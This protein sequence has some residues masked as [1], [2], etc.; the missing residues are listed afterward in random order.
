MLPAELLQQAFF[1]HAL[2]TEPAR[3]LPPHKSLLAM[4]ARAPSAPPP[5][6]LHARVERVV[7]KAFWDEALQSLSSPSPAVQLPRLKLLYNDLHEALTPLFPPQH[8]ILLTLAAPLS[9]TSSPLHSTL[10]LLNE[11]L[12]AL[13]QRCAPARDPDIDALLAN[14]APSSETTS[15]SEAP[16]ENPLAALIVSTLRDLISLADVL[17]RDLTDTLLGAMSEAQL[18]DVIRQQALTRERE[19]VLDPSMWGSIDRL[20]DLWK[21]WLGSENI[22]TSRLLRALTSPTPVTCQ[23]DDPHP[24]SLP[25]QLFF[26]RPDLLYIQNYLQALVIGASLNAL[27]RLPAPT[28]PG[29]PH[30]F[31]SRVW[32]LLKAEIDRD[33]YHNAIDD[34]SS[35]DDATK[36]VNLA[37]EVIRARM[38]FS[39]SPISEQDERELRAAVERTLRLQDPVFALLQSRLIRA[40]DQQIIEY[41]GGVVYKEKNQV[42]RFPEI[43]RTGR[44]NVTLRDYG[45]GTG[46][47]T[48]IKTIQPVIVV[49]GFEDKILIQAGGEVMEKLIA[50]ALWFK[51]V[52]EDTTPS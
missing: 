22:W 35:V 2:A 41:M 44:G 21:S 20:K 31:M 23:P 47:G 46:S 6:T 11:V 34:K 36:L 51:N 12:V 17:K 29:P 3:V 16:S 14:L 7:H 32:T 52:W 24:N 50:I 9:P 37:D 8:P 30:D 43:M 18:A 49:Q 28:S 27:V 15:V 13:R 1:L 45:S 38:L 33:E 25:P 5:S 10:A 39:A 48:P 40:I 26:S 19:I 42:V 4:L